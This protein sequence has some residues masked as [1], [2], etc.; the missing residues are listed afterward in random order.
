MNDL[1]ICFLDIESWTGLLIHI[2]Q[3]EKISLEIAASCQCK[4]ALI[5]C[6]MLI[7]IFLYFR[8]SESDEKELLRCDFLSNLSY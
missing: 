6:E 4:Q 5:Q 1:S 7:I 2:S 8:W 3:K